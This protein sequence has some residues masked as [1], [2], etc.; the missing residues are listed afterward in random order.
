MNFN[1][2]GVYNLFIHLGLYIYRTM[3]F[4]K[5]V[6]SVDQKSNTYKKYFNGKYNG[7]FFWY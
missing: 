3:K 4:F 6:L 7:E 2:S 1:R 5:K